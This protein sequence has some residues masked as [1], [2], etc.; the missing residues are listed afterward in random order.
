MNESNKAFEY[1]RVVDCKFERYAKILSEQLSQEAFTEGVQ[2]QCVES[3]WTELKTR[4]QGKTLDCCRSLEE[5]IQCSC[6][7]LLQELPAD[8]CRLLWLGTEAADKAGP[9]AFL[10]STHWSEL[11]GELYERVKDLALEEAEREASFGGEF[12]E[13]RGILPLV[14][15]VL[16]AVERREDLN[17]ETAAS[18]RKLM[19]VIDGL[20]EQEPT[21]FL[22]LSLDY[23]VRFEDSGG[24]RFYTIIVS[25][26]F[27]ELSLGGSEW[28][29]EVGSDAWSGPRLV[30]E[31]GGHFEE[32][33]DIEDMLL[34]MQDVAG[35]PEYEV[36]VTKED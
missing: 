28:R 27:L 23:T 6:S 20:P 9:S 25:P 14:K 29:Q 10:R 8:E 34:E 12:F 18:L 15:D 4:L 22:E 26:E 5:F 17:P 31:S 7:K 33:G 11:T 30:V 35:N 36:S 32:D 13:D 2:G 24:S 16:I 1:R 21:E 19:T 3:Y